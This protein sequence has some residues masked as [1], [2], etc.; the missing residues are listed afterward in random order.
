VSQVRKSAGLQIAQTALQPLT[1]HPELLHRNPDNLWRAWEIQAEDRADFI[2]LHKVVVDIKGSNF[3]APAS[4]EANGM[5]ELSKA[6]LE[7]M[8]ASVSSTN[9]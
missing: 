2:A 7:A 9:R 4:R 8:L 1:A 5:G 3:S 6:Q